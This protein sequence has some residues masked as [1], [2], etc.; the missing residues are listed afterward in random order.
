M[1]Q[2]TAMLYYSLHIPRHHSQKNFS[3]SCQLWELQLILHMYFRNWELVQYEILLL[4]RQLRLKSCITPIS[5]S[6]AA[7]YTYHRLQAINYSTGHG[8]IFLEDYTMAITL[9][10]TITT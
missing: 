7:Q 4:V 2:N 5:C 1:N 6:K 10:I 3:I 8:A 9:L